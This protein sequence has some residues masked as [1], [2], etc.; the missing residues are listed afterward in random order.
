RARAGITKPQPWKILRHTFGSRLAMAGVDQPAIQQFM[1][2]TSPTT[3]ARYM[4][5]S[6]T[7]LRDQMS[8]GLAYSE[9]GSG[10]THDA[11]ADSP[12]LEAAESA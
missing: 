11:P 6:P 9:A 12:A 10:A 3:T 5:L 1:G 2:H 7:Y 8:K 4:H